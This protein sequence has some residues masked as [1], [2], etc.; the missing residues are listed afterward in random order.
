MNVVRHHGQRPDALLAA[1]R[2]VRKPK[3]EIVPGGVTFEAVVSRKTYNRFRRE[4]HPPTRAFH[5]PA[6][7]EGELETK[8]KLMVALK[9]NGRRS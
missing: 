4:K 2:A 7:I 9:R 1:V 6:I 8:Y 3:Q 5:A